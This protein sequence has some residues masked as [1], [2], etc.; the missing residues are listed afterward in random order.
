MHALRCLALCSV[1]PLLL[2]CTASSDATTVRDDASELRRGRRNVGGVAPAEPLADA[3][4]LTVTSPQ[5]NASAGGTIDVVGLAPGFLNVEV[6]S[7][8]GDL[9]ARVTPDGAGN[10]SGPV[11]TTQLSNGSQTLILDAWDSPAG[12]EFAHH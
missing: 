10:F 12:T 9:L 2:G 1:A 6:H 4:T 3:Y 11:D 5:A 7:A 8:T